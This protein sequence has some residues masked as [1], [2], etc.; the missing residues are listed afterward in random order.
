MKLS[1]I[2]PTLNEAQNIPALVE[3]LEQA[4]GTVDYEVLIVDDNSPDQ[5]WAVAEQIGR[6]SCRER[7]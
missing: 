5:T 2:S 3:Q 4:L 1:V 6:A 7:V